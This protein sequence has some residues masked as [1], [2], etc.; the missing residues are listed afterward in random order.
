VGK[1]TIG[2]NLQDFFDHGQSIPVFSILGVNFGK[3]AKGFKVI[4]VQFYGI[5]EVFYGLQVC[6][7]LLAIRLGQKDMSINKIR[8]LVKGF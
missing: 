3:E 4:G 6:S 8:V 2:G 1:T 7:L 5:F